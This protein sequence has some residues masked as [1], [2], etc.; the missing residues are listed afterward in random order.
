MDH[1]WVSPSMPELQWLE[2]LLWNRFIF[3]S[4]NS[5]QILKWPSSSWNLFLVLQAEFQEYFFYI[6]TSEI[7]LRMQDAMMK[8]RSQT[9]AGTNVFG[10]NAICFHKHLKFFVAQDV[11]ITKQA[12]GQFSENLGRPFGWPWWCRNTKFISKKVFSK[13]DCFILIKVYTGLVQQ[14]RRQGTDVNI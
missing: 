14:L 10:I 3:L 1:V 9:L 12:E 13:S 5:Q 11:I 8:L 2:Q 7:C 4:W 6:N